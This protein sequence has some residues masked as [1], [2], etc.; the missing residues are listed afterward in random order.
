MDL[1]ITKN[2]VAYKKR[3]VFCHSSGGQKS[4]IR[5]EIQVSVG[6][7]SLWRLSGSREGQFLASQLLVAANMPWLLFTSLSSLSSRTHCLLSMCQISLC[8]SLTR[9]VVIE[10]M[11]HSNNLGLK[12]LKLSHIYESFCH[13]NYIHKFQGLGTDIFGD[14]YSIYYYIVNGLIIIHLYHGMLTQ[15]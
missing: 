4:K 3:N 2:L 11:A 12:F 7:Y 6:L 13:I 5:A 14:S 9:M 15:Q 1:L 10:F 8:L